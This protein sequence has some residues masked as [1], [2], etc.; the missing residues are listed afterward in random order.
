MLTVKRVSW[1]LARLPHLPRH[2]SRLGTDSGEATNTLPDAP[3][4]S[5]APPATDI[6]NN[7]WKWA[8][9]FIDQ[10]S[11]H[12]REGGEALSCHSRREE[13]GT[14]EVPVAPAACSAGCG[15]GNTVT[16]TDIFV[17]STDWLMWL[18]LPPPNYRL[19]HASFLRSLLTGWGYFYFWNHE[20]LYYLI[21]KGA[22][23]V[24]GMLC[25]FG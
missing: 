9:K 11:R 8:N 16:N 10:V 12:V 24:N 19:A 15:G 20:I 21:K 4:V 17:P 22:L 5:A 14:G 1:A 7:V 18:Q 23:V 2:P 13:R 6:K 3:D 25:D